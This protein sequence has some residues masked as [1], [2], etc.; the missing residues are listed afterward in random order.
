MSIDPARSGSA[1]TLASSA[2][3]LGVNVAFGVF[4][5]V[6]QQQEH[7]GVVFAGQLFLFAKAA[8]VDAAARGSVEFVVELQIFRAFR[9]AYAHVHVG[10]GVAGA[11]HRLN[12]LTG[13]DSAA[14][15]HV[16]VDNAERLDVLELGGELGALAAIVRVGIDGVARL[17]DAVHLGLDVAC[18]P[19][20]PAEVDVRLVAHNGLRG[21]YFIDGLGVSAQ[22]V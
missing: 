7:L 16:H 18:A 12:H 17:D 21:A 5:A 4:P 9:E 2:H 14:H 3:A 19:R 15:K 8:A 13:E 20:R 6:L 1:E 11:L 10:V 22:D